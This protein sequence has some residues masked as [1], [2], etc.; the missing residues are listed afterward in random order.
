M[1]SDNCLLDSDV[2]EMMAVLGHIAGLDD[3]LASKRRILLENL[4]RLIDADCWY[5]CLLGRKTPGEL[6]TFSVF[7]KGGFSE[8]QFAKYLTAQ[9]HPE[10]AMF[11]APILEELERRGSHITRLRQQ[12]D[13]ENRF[14]ESDV[15]RLWREADLA[16]LILSMRPGINGQVSAVALFR[17]FD[18]PLF[19]ERENRIAHVMLN[20]VP[21]LYEEAWPN[22]PRSRMGVLSPRLHTVINLL[23]QGM[24][25]KQIATEM[26]IS[27]HTLNGYIKEVY[28]RFEVHSQSELI[29]RFVEGDGGDRS[30]GDGAGI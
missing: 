10:M 11:N 8:E 9:E 5:W 16:P 2:R 25:R 19:N 1:D 17:N 14:P 4:A 12:V 6:P 20:S 18:R 24:G 3:D 26:G 27:I 15:F 28:A 7:L 30:I 22:H 21:W 29:R 23:L 13:P